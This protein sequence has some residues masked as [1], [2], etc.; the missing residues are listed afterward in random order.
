MFLFILIL[1][2]ILA[3]IWISGILTAQIIN[4]DK[5]YISDSKIHGK[6]VFAAKDYTK[7]EFIEV[8]VTGILPYITQG[9]GNMVNHSYTP[10]AYLNYKDGNHNISALTGIKKGD[11]ITINYKN[12]PWYIN[13][14]ESYYK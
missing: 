10:N 4:P 1:L 12:T 9:F 8:G 13:G 3:Y 2:I 7:D 6:G 5:F 11:E 14:P